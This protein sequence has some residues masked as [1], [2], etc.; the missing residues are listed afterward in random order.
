VR[1]FTGPHF[2]ILLAYA[3]QRDRMAYR[4][5][6]RLIGRDDR[7]LDGG[8][9]DEI[10]ESYGAAAAA[11]SGLVSIYPEVVRSEDGT[12]WRARRSRDA[13]LEVRVW[14]EDVA[15]ANIVAATRL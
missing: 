3:I 6:W 7:L 8:S 13:D 15:T 12:H 2:I 14:I 4:V 9:I 1:G 11:V 5:V 10:Y